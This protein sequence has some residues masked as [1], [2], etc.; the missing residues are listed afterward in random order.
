MQRAS[1]EKHLIGILEPADYEAGIDGDSGNMALLERI[2]HVLQFGAITGDAVLK[3][4]AGASAGTKTTA[5]AFKYRQS[6][7]DFKAASADVFGAETDVAST[8]LTLT[9]ATFDH[10]MIAIDFE[11][12][13]M[14]AGKPYLTMELSA[15]ASALNLS[16]LGIGSPRYAGKTQPTTL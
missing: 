15:A 7:G 13:D 4:Y 8:G 9:A 10:T 1:Y 2:E 5:L 3:F 11:S 14:P 6:Q 16:A 12:I